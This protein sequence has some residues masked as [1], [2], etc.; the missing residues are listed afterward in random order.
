MEDI[1]KFTIFNFFKYNKNQN[2]ETRDEFRKVKIKTLTD[3]SVKRYIRTYKNILNIY[4]DQYDIDNIRYINYIRELDEKKLYNDLK[5]QNFSEPKLGSFNYVIIRIYDYNKK[6]EN[7]ISFFR[8]L[9]LDF[10][11]RKTKRLQDNKL[12]RR[13]SDSWVTLEQL[14]DLEKKLYNEHIIKLL[15]KKRL[16]I[17]E[18]N[19]YQRYMILKFYN[20]YHLRNDLH[21]L[22]AIKERDFNKLKKEDNYK[23][24]NYIV[25][26]N[27]KNNIFIVLNNY[28]TFN[29]YGQQ[30][31]NIN[32]DDL[33]IIM[34]KYM[35]FERYRYYQDRFIK[36][37]MSKNFNTS[38][39][40]T[41]LRR[42]F[43]KELKIDKISVNILR[44]IYI[45]YETPKLKSVNEKKAY[46]KLMLHSQV[47]QALYFKNI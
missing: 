45:T 15:D 12:T 29:K 41:Y 10:N 11:K 13:Q 22:I 18:G 8:K 16:T 33:K 21:D 43:Y 3:G 34:F 25:F 17:N 37:A 1:N 32:N 5:K 4:F 30:T 42:F 47:E 46:A 28:K 35:E 24:D 31:I 23:K 9:Q 39:F 20:S 14:L 40:S 36:T 27:K 2:Y 26:N 44:H 6:Y 7:K 38:L 19:V